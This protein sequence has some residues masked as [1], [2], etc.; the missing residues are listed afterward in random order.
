MER[1]ESAENIRAL[2]VLPDPASHADCSLLLGNRSDH[3]PYCLLI[4]AKFGHVGQGFFP[5]GVGQLQ[6]PRRSTVR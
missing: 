6:P 1:S 3:L 2:T 5:I 4:L